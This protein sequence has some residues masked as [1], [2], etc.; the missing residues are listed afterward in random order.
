MERDDKSGVPK[1]DNY[2]DDYAAEKDD[3][4]DFNDVDFDEAPS[5][6][7]KKLQRSRDRSDPN[8]DFNREFTADF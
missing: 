4:M 7:R 1:I 6:T 8:P 3:P 5:K 2:E